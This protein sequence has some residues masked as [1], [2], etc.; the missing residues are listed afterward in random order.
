M[1]TNHICKMLDTIAYLKSEILELKSND[2]EYS[3]DMSI[4]KE[5]HTETKIYVKQIFDSLADL[6]TTLKNITEK[7]SKRWEQLISTLIAVATTAAATYLI[8][9]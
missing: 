4:L 3:K 2:K 1:E 5:S 7:P 8:T 6:S 9:K